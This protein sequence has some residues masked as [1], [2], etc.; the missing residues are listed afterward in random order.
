MPA[1]TPIPA[2]PEP[3]TTPVAHH[4]PPV[5][6]RAPTPAVPPPTHPP[7]AAPGPSPLHSQPFQQ[8]PHP[9]VGAP[10]PSGTSV[11]RKGRKRKTKKQYPPT[12]MGLFLWW[13]NLIGGAVMSIALF[14]VIVWAMVASSRPGSTIDDGTLGLI[15]LTCGGLALVLGIITL[16]LLV[17]TFRL[18]RDERASRGERWRHVELPF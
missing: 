1:G 7:V 10:D 3:S 14:A 9:P 8:T 4:S 16:V 11:G 18:S 17:Q 2:T 6:H 13:L 15:V 5:A 12:K